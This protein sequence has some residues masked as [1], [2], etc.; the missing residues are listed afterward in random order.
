MDM[1]LFLL[2][3][4]SPLYADSLTEKRIKFGLD[5][6]VRMINGVLKR[7]RIGSVEDL[8]LFMSVKYILQLTLSQPVSFGK[9]KKER[10]RK[11]RSHRA[12]EGEGEGEEEGGRERRKHALTRLECRRL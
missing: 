6:L 4:P 2:S 3:H 12:G 11:G 1:M 10:K 8:F 7:P 9:G 5:K